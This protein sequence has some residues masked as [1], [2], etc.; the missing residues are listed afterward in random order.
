MKKTWDNPR[1]H[2]MHEH[3]RVPASFNI[4]EIVIAAATVLAPMAGVTDTVFSRFISNAIL[5]TTPETGLTV[6]GAPPVHEA[7]ADFNSLGSNSVGSDVAA[8]N[9]NQQSGCG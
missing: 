1:E 3:A 5:F 4:G 9:S 6:L 7:S 8:E 2:A